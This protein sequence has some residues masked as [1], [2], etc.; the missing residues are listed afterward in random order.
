MISHNSFESFYMVAFL[1]RKNKNINEFK[2]NGQNIIT[3]KTIT[4]F[5]Q[6][7]HLIYTAA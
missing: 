7:K 4:I 6:L 3:S 1:K 2:L 5:E